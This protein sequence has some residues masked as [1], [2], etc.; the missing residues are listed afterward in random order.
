MT[1]DSDL[2]SDGI[3]CVWFPHPE[4]TVNIS[5]FHFQTLVEAGEPEADGDSNS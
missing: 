2:E 3:R 1:V 4:S 5:I